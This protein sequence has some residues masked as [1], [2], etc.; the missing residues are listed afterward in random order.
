MV[1]EFIKEGI[2]RPSRSPYAS[3]ILLR[4][5]PNGTHRMCIDYRKINQKVIKDR[6]SL[7]LMEDIIEAQTIKPT[8]EKE[9][10]MENFPKPK[11]VKN[12][13]S[14][15]GL[16]GFFRK[17]IA[18]YALMARPLTNLLKDE[19]KF[20]FGQEEEHAFNVLKEKLCST[21]VL[22]LYDPK[23]ETQ[24]LTDASAMGYG[25]CLLQ[26]QA[27][28]SQ[29][30]PVYFL[31]YKTTPAESKLHSYELEVLAIIRCLAKLRSYLLGIHFPI[32]R[33]VRLSNRQ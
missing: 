23:A 1:D 6:F 8:N 30:H 14:F 4:K 15:L 24:L 32:F 13:Q 11:N 18:D 10:A 2:V 29:F 7:P 17:F 31:S 5:K 16:T 22:K 28:D 20:K 33:I 21:P 25:G 9:K 3:P 27:D 26:K 19:N 12:V